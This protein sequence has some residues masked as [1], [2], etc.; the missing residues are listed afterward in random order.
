MHLDCFQLFNTRI[1]TELMKNVCACVRA[2][3][4]YLCAAPRSLDFAPHDDDVFAL[5]HVA[6]FLDAPLLLRRRL[7]AYGVTLLVTVA[8]VSATHLPQWPA[9]ASTVSR[10][11]SLSAK[12]SNAFC[13][14]APSP[15]V[16][17][18]S[19]IQE[20]RSRCISR[21]GKANQRRGGEGA[22]PP[23]Q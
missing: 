12:P 7:V 23:N 13:P 1:H 11:A 16:L 9:A 15:F 22:S 17:S 4:R 5:L 18:L 8:H 10:A 6:N 14:C 19:S 20:R 2:L 21:S 3:T